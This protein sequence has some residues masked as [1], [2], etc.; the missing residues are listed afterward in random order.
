MHTEED[1]L[2]FEAQ[3]DKTKSIG[4]RRIIEIAAK[5]ISDQPEALMNDNNVIITVVFNKVS[6]RVDFRLV[7][8]I[9]YIPYGAEYYEEA[10]VSLVDNRVSGKSGLLLSNKNKETRDSRCKY[11]YVASEEKELKIKEILRLNNLN[12]EKYFIDHDTRLVTIKEKESYYDMQIGDSPCPLI[13][14]IDKVSGKIYDDVQINKVEDEFYP[15]P[16]FINDIDPDP[17]PWIEMK[18]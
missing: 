17:D 11:L 15:S 7:Y 2:T 8:P 12:D 3:V 13:Y 1:Q 5:S 14:K 10:S 9:K 18:E 16:S 4:R 6:L